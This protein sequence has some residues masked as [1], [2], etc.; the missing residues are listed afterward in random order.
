MNGIVVLGAALLPQRHAREAAA[1]AVRRAAARATRR[2]VTRQSALLAALDAVVDLESSD[3]T[4]VGI[5]AD[6][7][8]DGV[9]LELDALVATSDG[10][11]GSVSC[12]R[13]TQHP[14]L[15]ASAVREHGA[16]GIVSG[17]AAVRFARSVGF[18]ATDPR[19]PNAR[20]RALQ[21]KSPLVVREEWHALDVSA[22]MMAPPADEGVPV[23]AAIARDAAGR[24]AL[25]ASA[26]GLG[27]DSGE[28]SAV[29]MYGV[30]SFVGPLGALFVTGP[31]EV[32]VRRAAA[33]LGY[34]F[35]ADGMRAREACDALLASLPEPGRYAV[36]ALS[37]SEAGVARKGY[38]YP[39]A[40]V[41]L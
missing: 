19:T 11:I 12:V 37:I 40:I 41:T 38:A 8:R 36:I 32:L 20:Q 39:S 24:F 25:A 1:S 13:D 17:D 16:Q 18:T 10:G 21:A 14:V 28:V 34:S 23:V 2:L 6:F 26:G 5:G 7:R 30:T 33:R 31:R 9:S 29:A 35:I 22:A 4:S 15:L 3:A 27:L